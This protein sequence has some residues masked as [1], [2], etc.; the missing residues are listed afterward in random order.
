MVFLIPYF[1][2]VGFD[3]DGTADKFF[4]Y[5]LFQGL[6]MSVMVFLGHLLTTALPTAAVGNG[7]LW[8]SFCFPP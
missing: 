1:F 2:I 5:W 6:Y 8:C 3:K 4:W 7:K